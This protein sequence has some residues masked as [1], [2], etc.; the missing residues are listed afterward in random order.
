MGGGGSAHLIWWA[1]GRGKDYGG[2]V[3]DNLPIVAERFF[4]L[5]CGDARVICNKASDEDKA[6]WDYVLNFPPSSGDQRPRDEQPGMETVF[7]QVKS[8]TRAGLS[9]QLKLSNALWMAKEPHPYFLVLIKEHAKTRRIFAR[10]FWVAEIEDT[11]RRVR[12][13]E[14]SGKAGKLN[15]QA[16]TLTLSEADEHTDDLLAWMH[17]TMLAVRGDYREAKTAITNSVGYAA[18]STRVSVTIK[19]SPDE[20][21]DWELGLRP[22]PAISAFRLT[23]ERFGIELPDPRFEG[24]N[25]NV[26]IEPEGQAC[27]V[28]LRHLADLVSVT[29][30]GKL[31]FSILS[32]TMPGQQRPWRAD[33]GFLK[34][35]WR[36]GELRGGL[37]LN[38]DERISLV[39]LLERL[40]IAGW[41]GE[42]SVSATLF[43]CGERSDLGTLDL[44]DRSDDRDGWRELRAWAGALE[45]VAKGHPEV[46]PAMS[47]ADL[48]QSGAWLKRFYGLL[49]GSSLKIEH[50]PN[51]DDDP[52]HAIIYRLRC[53]AGSYSFFAIVRRE[54]ALDTIRD[55][56]RTLYL[57][58]A[59]ILDSFV[60]EG[61]WP[62]NADRVLPT[63]E[64]RVIQ[65]GDPTYFWDM[66]D[67]E[68]WI[69]RANASHENGL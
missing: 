25:I 67:M 32:P 52:T 28:T 68:E 34:L 3:S 20:I 61:S 54:V 29:L 1:N 7:V 21:I 8:S 17:G 47:I 65:M 46:S 66:G 57:K 63:Y 43:A 60:F 9:V 40:A 55:G 62:E 49:T 39:H 33:F 69:S 6:G 12:R 64:R 23:R 11:L 10:H 14:V 41:S 36:G 16:F 18:N 4:A 26:S 5:L 27:L 2:G 15:R 56:L 31:F 13:A 19:A 51:V 30:A 45:V 50:S 24:G 53:D 38:F 37:D 44:P 35:M 48:M 59:E 58:D 42:E 22:T